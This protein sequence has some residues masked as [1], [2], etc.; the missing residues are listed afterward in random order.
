M[1]CAHTIGLIDAGPF[2]DCPRAHRDAAWRHARQCATCGP[3]LEAAGGLT[4]SLAALPQLAPPRDL[5]G[6]VLVRIAR[7]EEAQVA[8]ASAAMPE[9]RLR[10]STRDWSAWATTLGALAA[11]LAIVLSVPPGDGVPIDTVSSAVGGLTAG[12]LAMPATT[13]GVL[14][15]TAGL[16]LYVAGLFAPLVRRR[17]RFPT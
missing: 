16:V 15:L 7:F 10:A 17:W 11:A 13:A 5:T 4:A 3:A 9:T 1:T 6:D 2:I 14:A 12:P 8:P